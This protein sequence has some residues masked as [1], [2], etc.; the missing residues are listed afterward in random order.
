MNV[1][2]TD[3]APAQHS[4]QEA[5]A[6]A[7][8]FSKAL[9]VDV[10]VV[11]FTKVGGSA[12]WAV[13]YDGYHADCDAVERYLLVR[14]CRGGELVLLVDEDES[15]G[16]YTVSSRGVALIHHKTGALEPVDDETAKMV[17]EAL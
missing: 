9:H 8:R 16:I 11:H 1:L 10:E 13:S 6:L 7:M 3:E 17:V 5:H 12:G 14:T 2:S 15:S 4:F